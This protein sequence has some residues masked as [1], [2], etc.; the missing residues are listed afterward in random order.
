MKNILIIVLC[1]TVELYAQT[2]TD[3]LSTPLGEFVLISEE[4]IEESTGYLDET[5][6]TSDGGTAQ[7][8]ELSSG[9]RHAQPMAET[10][11]ASMTI[12]MMPNP[13]AG[14]VEMQIKDVAGSVSI[15]ITDLLGQTVYTTS[16]VVDGSRTAYLPAQTWSSGTYIV[17]VRG[18][19]SNIT[20][21]LVVR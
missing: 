7:L 9:A 18:A 11:S 3:S 10:V 4:E 15:S 2:S 20:E 13:T 17:N 1:S 6:T 8:I 14:I 5:S 16:L 19:N 21:R 12:S